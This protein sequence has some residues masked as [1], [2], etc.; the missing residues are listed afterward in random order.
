MRRNVWV[1]R[2]ILVAFSFVCSLTSIH[3]STKQQWTNDSDSDSDDRAHVHPIRVSTRIDVQ[4]RNVTVHPLVEKQESSGN[5]RVALMDTSRTDTV[6]TTA[7]SPLSSLDSFRAKYAPII[8]SSST[9]ELPSKETP[10]RIR[11][12]LFENQARLIS[13][14][15]GETWAISDEVL[16]ICMDGWNRS[17]YFDFVEATVVPDFHTEP[18]YVLREQQDIVWVVDMRRI[19]K[20]K[21]YT[22]W[23]QL[24]DAANKTLEWQRQQDNVNAS[25]KVVLM[26][27]RDRSKNPSHCNK[28]IIQLIELLGVGNVVSVKQQVVRARAWNE[29][30]QFPD[31]GRIWNSSQDEACFGRPTLRVPYTVRSDYAEAVQETYTQFLAPEQDTSNS[32][33]LLPPD[34]VRTRTDVAHFWTTKRVG[35]KAAVLRNAVTDLVISLNGTTPFGSRVNPLRAIGG[36]V[37]VGLSIGRT[38]VSKEY[39]ES[40]L[41]SKIVVVAQRDSWED[42]YRLFEAISCGALVMTDPML[43]LP[44]EL[45]DG[46]HIIVYRSLDH[47]R[48]LV[49]YYLDPAHKDERL[50]IA[51]AGWNLAMGRH[52]TFHWMEELFFGQRISA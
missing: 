52:R 29:T 40:L 47:L 12:L 18:D 44:D 34:T 43:S 46:E 2:R 8:S 9:T 24:L 3:F 42:H 5:D 10:V 33:S 11:A 32:T 45:V 19:L 27:Y 35:S 28:S 50:R 6:A 20:G 37:S 23:L 14:R 15:K 26:D 36:A 25:L 39:L 13:F 1:L 22:V 7:V 41:T 4:R 16:N 48:E 17:P 30:T 21:K 49:L 51:R 31:P 38:K